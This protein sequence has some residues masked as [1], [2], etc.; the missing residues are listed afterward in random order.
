MSTS[1]SDA[2]DLL[3]GPVPTPFSGDFARAQQFIDE[4]GQLE[5]RNR[6][7]PFITQPALRVDLALVFI[8]ED[9]MTTTWKR[10][11][12]RGSPVELA[13]E[14]IWDE[15]FDSFCTAWIDDTPAPVTDPAPVLPPH[16]PRRPVRPRITHPPASTIE[17]D[18]AQTMRFASSL[19]PVTVT[20]KE[21][22]LPAS[23]PPP[24]IETAIHAKTLVSSQIVA[25]PLPLAT[26]TPPVPIY[27]LESVVTPLAATSESPPMRR[28]TSPRIVPPPLPADDTQILPVEVD[29]TRT[30]RFASLLL[31]VD[32]I[33]K[34]LALLAS[35]PAP[36]TPALD[37][38]FPPVPSTTASNSPPPRPPRS[39]H[40]PY[41][42]KIARQPTGTA[43]CPPC[44]VVEDDNSPRRGVK[45]LVNS[46]FASDLAEPTTD[47]ST[48]PPRRPNIFPRHA[49]EMPRDPDELANR[50]ISD[51]SRKT[52]RPQ[53]PTQ[54]LTST[55]QRD[56][57]RANAAE[58]T[59]RTR[60]APL[61]PTRDPRE[62]ILSSPPWAVDTYPVGLIYHRVFLYH[63]KQVA[64]P[65][66]YIYIVDHPMW[67][68][69]VPVEDPP[70]NVPQADDLHAFITLNGDL[71]PHPAE[72][73]DAITNRLQTSVV[74]VTLRPRSTV[75]NPT[76]KDLWVPFRPYYIDRRGERNVPKRYLQS[77]FWKDD[78]EIP[79]YVAYYIDPK[80]QQHIIPVEFNFE[81]TCWTEIRW[82]DPSNKFLV[83]KPASSAL[84]LDIPAN[85]AVTRNQWGPI[86]GETEEPA[87][88]PTPKTP[89]PSP[90]LA[91]NPED[92]VIKDEQEEEALELIAKSIPTTMSQ[93]V[94][95][96]QM[97]IGTVLFNTKYPRHPDDPPPGGDLGDNNG[98]GGG[99]GDGRLP[100]ATAP[101]D[102]IQL[103]D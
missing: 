62:L 96:E 64:K 1:I 23:A 103:T 5:R 41:S 70:A 40:R 71:A 19:P 65:Y 63:N 83:T 82:S 59:P 91:S 14:S 36:F 79:G 16:S 86:D 46:A 30:T 92:I 18:N 78:P 26:T 2:M 89:A 39:P 57:P 84:N 93:T 56:D 76:T 100:A 45:T 4:F 38:P 27:T 52:A 69:I 20:E 49:L 6:H 101:P 75:A 8:D 87:R 15:F 60:L 31:L 25:D 58:T 42:P 61:T 33:E 55:P 80:N 74:D 22:A 9:P 48:L 37:P 88:S 66:G 3:V 90:S 77:A 32:E 98:G 17:V 7:H 54:T 53:T 73:P 97:R 67:R 29:S 13:D 94:T 50:P 72:Y 99:G 35:A 68:T 34:E 81:F 85:Q 95:H 43:P 28:P 47:D 102:P 12:R 11:I 51:Q 44:T 10:T 24:T 21:E